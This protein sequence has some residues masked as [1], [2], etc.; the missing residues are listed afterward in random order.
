MNEVNNHKNMESKEN[1]ESKKLD[2][3]GDEIVFEVK[4]D[5]S[6]ETFYLYF[7]FLFGVFI[8]IS[9]FINP[10]DDI[11]VN[12]FMFIVFFPITFYI[13]KMLFYNRKN[14]IYVTNY[15]IGFERRHWFKMQK[16]FFRF[17]EVGLAI[18]R[19]GVGV[20]SE[21]VF[22]FYPFNNKTPK[23]VPLFSPKNYYKIMLQDADYSK[24]FFTFIRQKT[25]E[26]LESQGKSISDEELKEK[27]K[28]LLYKDL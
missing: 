15:G 18:I 14:R 10:S 20:T 19:L 4:H 26:A 27:I 5:T 16:G 24:V 25:K 13:A 3:N 9:L 17:G 22:I 21:E 2:S 12:I 8:L 11:V 1:A 28:H 6:I 7:L 23:R